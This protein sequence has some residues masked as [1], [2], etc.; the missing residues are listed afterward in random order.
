[1][2]L[3]SKK[4]LLINILAL[5]CLIIGGVIYLIYRNR[6]LVMFR[7]VPNNIIGLLNNV[8]QYI[9]LPHGKLSSFVV[10][11]LPAGLWTIS[12]MVLMRNICNEMPKTQKLIWVYSL[13]ILLL[14][15]ELLQSVIVRLGTFDL[16]DMLCYLIP[17]L[18]LLI[19]D[20]RNEND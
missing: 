4:Q 5:L 6:T 16:L 3:K 8:R 19:I 17:I 11:N 10:Y 15:I 1:M 18:V 12:Y 13:P 7:L 2:T 9:D 14:M 20:L